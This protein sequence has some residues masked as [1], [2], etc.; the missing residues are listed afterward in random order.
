M[1][2]FLKSAGSEADVS[3][4]G[5][6]RR[7]GGERLLAI[8][9]AALLSAGVLG[10]TTVEDRDPVGDAERRAAA[11]SFAQEGIAE[12]SPGARLTEQ[13]VVATTVLA[14]S[15][16]I[17]GSPDAR[18]STSTTT[19][20]GST[21]T[22]VRTP[23]RPGTPTSTTQVTS[24]PR[25]PPAVS[26]TGRWTETNDGVSVRMRMEPTAPVAGEPVT[27][28][29]DDLVAGDPCCMVMM[30][31][32]DMTG[33]EPVKDATCASPSTRTGLVATH[34]YASPGIYRVGLFT[35]T[36]PCP[37]GSR[38]RGVSIQACIAVGPLAAG[39]A[40]CPPLSGEIGW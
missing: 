37:A 13:T 14:S 35:A 40:T 34:T 24:P 10:T 26:P 18:P 23:V 16:T 9:V 12:E 6:H 27:F 32:G 36:V 19:T 21:V 3:Q 17:A 25:P 39:A 5:H 1:T 8:A 11:A 20:R 30:M 2:V 22:T 7:W 33:F 29:I 4:V 31:F 28:Y 15:S 38:V